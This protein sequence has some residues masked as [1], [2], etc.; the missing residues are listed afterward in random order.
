VAPY[1][2]N[3]PVAIQRRY[4]VAPDTI[5]R[6]G[7]PDSRVRRQLSYLQAETAVTANTITHNRELACNGPGDEASMTS[8]IAGFSISSCVILFA[9]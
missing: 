9:G 1:V 5:P 3:R 4:Q 8:T 6:A 7:D 2:F